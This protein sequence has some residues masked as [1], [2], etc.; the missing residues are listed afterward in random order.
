[1]FRKIMAVSHFILYFFI[2]KRNNQTIK[3][4]KAIMLVFTL[5]GI[6]FYSGCIN[7]EENTESL[8]AKGTTLLKEGKYSEAIECFDKAIAIDPKYAPAWG[9]KGSVLLVQEKYSEAIECY[10]KAIALDPNYALAWYFKGW[11]LKSLGRNAEA[12]ECFDKAK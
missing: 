9:N 2:L 5:I 11:A 6:I 1:M 4:G 12:Q 10:D 3:K 8:Y 7:Q